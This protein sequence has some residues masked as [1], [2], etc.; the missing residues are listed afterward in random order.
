MGI[1]AETGFKFATNDLHE[2]HRAIA[3]FR[4]KI[5]P[6][7][8]E[9][10]AKAIADISTNV[11]DMCSCGM[12]K[13]FQ[14]G[15]I[16]IDFSFKV[17]KDRISKLEETGYLDTAIDFACDC[18]IFPIKNATI[19]ILYTEFK[20]C[21]DIWSRKKIVKEYAYSDDMEIPKGVSEE[22]WDFRRDDWENAL[23]HYDGIPAMNGLLA[24]CID[25]DCYMINDLDMIV[26]YVPPFEKR[27]E[28]MAIRRVALKNSENEHVSSD[29]QEFFAWLKEGE[30]AELYKREKD[31][32]TSS[33]FPTITQNRLTNH[34]K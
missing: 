14:E 1:N 25:R 18:V 24:P 16:P 6:V 4:D 31:I 5:A 32:V 9:K 23:K 20:E 13:Y 17:I 22:E 28:E 2:I 3:Q 29:V 26:E 11:I 7:A 10:S 12:D 15:T 21:A 19:G 33:L 8:K 34:I 30:G 27:V